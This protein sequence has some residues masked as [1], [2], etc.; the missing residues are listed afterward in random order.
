LR[1]GISSLISPTRIFRLEV[2]QIQES[3]CFKLSWGKGQQLSV[4]LPYPKSLWQF[5]QQWEIA[6]QSFYQEFD[7]SSLRGQAEFS[8]TISQLEVD[9]RARLVEAEASLLYEFQYWLR[10]P[11]LYEIKRTIVRTASSQETSLPI[12]VF[13]TCN[14]LE[15]ARFP[16]ENWQIGLEAGLSGTIRIARTPLNI[17][18]QTIKPQNRQSRILVILGDD[19]GLSFKTELETLKKQLNNLVYI[20][21]VGWKWQVSS[22]DVT[23][24]KAQIL[25]ALSTEQ[26]WDALLFLGHS[27]ETNLT[28]GELAIAPNT[29][30]FLSEI[31]P[32]LLKAKERG[33]QFALFNSCNGIKIAESLID[34][35]LSQVAIMRQPIHNTVAQK[36][37]VHFLTALGSDR[38]VHS[39]MLMATQN[40]LQSNFTFP[41]A[42]LIP[43][44]FQHPEAKLFQI[45]PGGIKQ[46]LKQLIPKR[47]EALFL[48][49]ILFLSLSPLQ[50][51]LLDSR[52]GIQAIYRD[53]T[54]QNFAAGTPPVL[55]I[56]VDRESLKR[57]NI[58]ARK[59]KPIDRG[60]IA[61]LIKA[62]SDRHSKVIGIDY[63]LAE[64]TEEDAVLAQSLQNTSEPNIRFVFGADSELGRAKWI[65]NRRSL[66]ADISFYPG[67][68]E[69]PTSPDSCPANCPFA[70][71]LALIHQENSSATP[72]PDFRQNKR[73]S[74]T[75]IARFSQ[76]LEQ[77]W[78][79]PIVDFSISPAEVYKPVS[80]W[81]LIE[82]PTSQEVISANFSESIILIAP[83]GYSDAD[84]N[85]PLPAAIAYWRSRSPQSSIVP[86]VW[87]GG[88][89]HAY[90]IHHLLY[91]R[92][93]IPIPDL[94]MV[95]IAALLGKGIALRLRE[96]QSQE[97]RWLAIAFWG[98]TVVYG[99]F[100]LQIYIS[101]AIL[102]PWLLPSIMLWAYIQPFLKQKRPQKN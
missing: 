31:A 1:N 14:T 4:T 52:V 96:K 54:Q 76:L 9:W 85:F 39:A 75:K 86:E 69:L 83:G 44:L 10:H 62:V 18:H 81:K 87:T 60:Y 20:E 67:Y 80:A 95:A 3:C 30:I 12:E 27:N 48:T 5:Y 26:G 57:A 99:F 78:F 24:I 90:M 97:H 37:L 55:S 59:I 45:N 46:W 7:E 91:Q 50:S 35:G 32:Q 84:D 93:V 29:S 98:G 51:L 53:L 102:L 89:V 68:M 70:Y 58:D 61:K 66:E 56:Q 15:L 92:L 19:T 33:L 38:D 22:N 100:S 16:W 21:Y 25:D 82:E 34:L 65:D 43:S 94:L 63:L 41:S 49:S 40:L 71:L 77:S 72:K 88:E 74:V 64:P 42:Y 36:F 17:R 79:Q 47:R 2:Q 28:G 11:E 23:E 101:Q 8:G 6:Y 13:L 73:A